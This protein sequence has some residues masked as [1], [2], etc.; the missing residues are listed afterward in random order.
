MT[1]SH[2]SVLLGVAAVQIELPYAVRE[3]LM[4][5]E[6]LFSRFAAAIFASYDV[7]VASGRVGS[8]KRGPLPSLD[9]PPVKV[10]CTQLSPADVSRMY[11]DCQAV[12]S[13]QYHGRTI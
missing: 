13:A 10:R 8:R 11:A 12:D 2:Q 1:M 6:Q 4:L 5:D 7:A 9:D 3:M